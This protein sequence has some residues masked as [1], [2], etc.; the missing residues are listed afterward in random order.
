MHTFL[1]KTKPVQQSMTGSITLPTKLRASPPL[2]SLQHT[3]GNQ[4]VELLLKSNA[5]AGKTSATTDSKSL[6]S[7]EKTLNGESNSSPG[8]LIENAPDGGVGPLDAGVPD[9]G[10]PDAGVPKKKA[11]VDSF[12]VN[13]KKNSNTTAQHPSLRLDYSVKFTKDAT[14]DPA[15]AEFRQSVFT[16]YEITAGPGK[17]G[18][19]DNSP[20]HNDNY[21][22]ADDTAGNGIKD[23]D[24]V[25]ND[26]PGLS[27]LDK[28]DVIDYSFTA[29]QTII[30]TGDGNKVIATRG[31]HTA[32]IKG[33]HPRTFDNVPKTLN[34]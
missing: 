18:K 12:V 19:F 2:H 6:A 11:G 29:M 25:S 33:K 4:A 8:I 5:R 30:D 24:F 22:R 21:S 14:H 23:T 17:S 9:A 20:I 32:T 15:M 1:E 13:W 31:P 7:M 3:A 16:T 26:N 27:P 28:D 10:V 34:S